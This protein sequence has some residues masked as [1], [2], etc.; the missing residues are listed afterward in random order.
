MMEKRYRW[1]NKQIRRHV[2]VVDGKQ[3]P[4]KVFMNATYLHPYIRQWVQGNVWVC[5]DRIVYVGPNKP[6][7]LDSCEVVD[8]SNQVLVAGYMEPH[9]HPF[10]LYNPHTLAEYAAQHGTTTLIN[11]NLFLFLQLTKKK[12]FSFLSAME[13]QPVTMYWWC[14]L[15]PQTEMDGEEHFFSYKNMKGWLENDAVLQVGE[16]TGWPKLLEGDDFILHWIQ[17]AKKIGKKVEGHFPGASDR[18]LTKMKLFGADADHEAMTGSDVYKRLMQGYTVSLRHSSIRPDLPTLLKEMR[19]CGIHHYD[20]CMFTTDGST[21]AFYENGMIDEMIRIALQEGVSDIDAY[22][23]ATWNVARYYNMDH[24]HGSITPGRIAHINI[25]EHASNPTPISVLASG[26]WVKRDGVPV[27]VFPTVNWDIHGLSPLSLSWDLQMDDLQFSMPLGMYMENSVIIKPY[28]ISIDTSADELSAD[29]DESFLMLIDRDGKWRVNT[30]LKGFATHVQ[31][32][33]S[34]YSNTGDII[35]IGKSKRDLLF[36]FERM[37]QIGGGIILC[38]H[39]EIIHEIPLPLGGLMSAKPMEVLME[40]E[41][42]LGELLRARGYAFADP[43]YTLLFLSSTHLPYIRI[44]PKGIY[45]VMH[46]TVLFPT[47]MR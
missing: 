32:L 36:A 38:E 11:D 33:V 43:I 8:C 7:Q 18:T 47:I 21:P 24:L 20:H 1:K 34:S 30:I 16:L 42:T 23:M 4:T 13:K 10:Q 41:K 15:D 25:L 17:E 40:E 12:A 5:D 37:K 45:D 31:A 39:G 9:A 44:T 28:S 27:A 2:A 29:H 46:K 14:R 6:K 22:S 35:L 26:Q 19:Q 3:A